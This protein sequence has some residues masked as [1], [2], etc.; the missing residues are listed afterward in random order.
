MNCMF[1]I[2]VLYCRH[3]Q[4]PADAMTQH[5]AA[6]ISMRMLTSFSGTLGRINK[7]EQLL[8]SKR[9]G[10]CGVYLYSYSLEKNDLFTSDKA[11]AQLYSYGQFYYCMTSPEWCG[12][13]AD[14]ID[15]CVRAGAW[16]TSSDVLRITGL[17][18]KLDNAVNRCRWG[19][20]ILLLM[21]LLIDILFTLEWRTH[22]LVIC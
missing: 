17:T 4:S 21:S 10:G 12:D 18:R 13:A 2:I 8:M 14:L 6:R 3:R 15:T 5:H 11:I 19:H 16:K 20:V 7:V 1:L 9:W 22:V